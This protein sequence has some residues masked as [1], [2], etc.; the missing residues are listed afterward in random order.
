MACV[1]LLTYVRCAA[2]ANRVLL[3]FNKIKIINA[4]LITAQINK[5]Q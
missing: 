5:N 4:I 1:S 2:L 3:T